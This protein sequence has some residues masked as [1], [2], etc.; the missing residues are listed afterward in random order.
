MCNIKCSILEN[1]EA[2]VKS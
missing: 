1:T 2:S